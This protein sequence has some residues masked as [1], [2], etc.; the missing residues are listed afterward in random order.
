MVDNSIKNVEQLTIK[1]L[2]SQE[3]YENLVI[4]RNSKRCTHCGLCNDICPSGVNI[5]SMEVIENCSGCGRCI[6]NCPQKA[7]TATSSIPLS[8][9]THDKKVKILRKLLMGTQTLNPDDVFTK[10]DVEN[11]RSI[12]GISSEEAWQI[13]DG[14]MY[15]RYGVIEIIQ[16]KLSTNAYRFIKSF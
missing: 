14:L 4:I 7:L 12:M 2:D 5:Q 15:G 10:A 1:N 9:E 11:M 16:P 13:I 3:S 6:Q 8:Y